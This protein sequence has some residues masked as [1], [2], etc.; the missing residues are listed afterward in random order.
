MTWFSLSRWL[1]FEKPHQEATIS[2][3]F[4]QDTF[5]QFTQATIS[6]NV[7][8]IGELADRLH[9]AETA[10][11]NMSSKLSSNTQ[12]LAA[13][14]QKLLELET[15][16]DKE[17]DILR[18]HAS[19]E[20][21]YA[22]ELSKRLEIQEVDISNNASQLENGEYKNKERHSFC[23]DHINGITESVNKAFDSMREDRR[24]I[25]QLNERL[26]KMDKLINKVAR[27]IKKGNKAKAEKDVGVLK[28]ADKVQ[29]KKLAKLQKKAPRAKKK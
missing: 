21:D 5:N 15:R 28:K 24:I 6:N 13:Q 11:S 1:Q 9:N 2:S 3:V 4:D 10:I 8:A 16:I 29:D 7:S 23:V 14:M 25:N 26:N 20:H 22:L 17:I 12:Y 27:D 19:S 18:H